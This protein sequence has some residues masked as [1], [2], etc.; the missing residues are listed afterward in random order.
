M[1]HAFAFS[2]RD[3]LTRATRHSSPRPFMDDTLN[4]NDLHDGDLLFYMAVRDEAPA[5]AS[6]A[7]RVFHNRHAGYVLR[8][9]RRL[10]RGDGA[11]LTDRGAED[12]TADTLLRAF[13]RAETFDTPESDPDAIRRLVRGW[14]GKIAENI[15]RSVLRGQLRRQDVEDV[16]AIGTGA[17]P[18]NDPRVALVVE[19]LGTLTEKEHRVLRATAHWY[20][21]DL[22]HFNPPKGVMEDLALELGVLPAS[23]RKIR[24][25]ALSKLKDYM[26]ICTG[27][28]RS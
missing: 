14:L 11:L 17:D 13:E 19:G 2:C 16:E 7:W 21:E 8:F 27:E 18:G 22:G 10:A 1:C 3:A 5:E 24:E 12:L 6:Q 4:W 9:C 28:D 20:D 25:R 23:L 26:E 15:V